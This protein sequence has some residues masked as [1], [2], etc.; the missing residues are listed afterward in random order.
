LKETWLY[1]AAPRK[2]LFF[3]AYG[4]EPLVVPG[5]SSALAAPIFTVIS[6]TKCIVVESVVVC[7]G[8]GRQRKQAKLPGYERT[9]LILMGVARIE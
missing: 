5:V 8:V 7:T 2:V 3:P 4:I 9:V 6:V 1:T